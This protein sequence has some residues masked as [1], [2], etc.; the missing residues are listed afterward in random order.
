MKY[1]MTCTEKVKVTK[2][3]KKGEKDTYRTTFEDVDSANKIT[4]FGEKLD[5]A[6]DDPVTVSLEFTKPQQK[7]EAVI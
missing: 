3:N 5:V 6:I 2:E 7:L 1:N 4:Y